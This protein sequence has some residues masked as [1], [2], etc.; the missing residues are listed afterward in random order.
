MK[1][2]KDQTVFLKEAAR[3]SPLAL[4]FRTITMLSGSNCNDLALASSNDRKLNPE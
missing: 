3:G 2:K 4:G 1:M